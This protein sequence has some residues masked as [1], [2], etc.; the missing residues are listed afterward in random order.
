MVEMVHDP[1]IEEISAAADG[2]LPPTDRRALD[3]HLAGC[4]ECTALL[5]RFEHD[6]RRRRIDPGHAGTS[7]LTERVLATMADEHRRVHRAGHSLVRRAAAALAVVGIAGA[8]L[9]VAADVGSH[10]AA[11][12]QRPAVT[13]HA[14]AATFRA[15]E[16]IVAPGSTVEWHNDSDQHHQLVSSSG[17]IA[18]A[19]DLAPGG[20]RTE[21]FRVPGTYE[22]YC[23]VHA[24]MAGRVRVE[25]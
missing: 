6:R 11:D 17:A 12:A 22:F 24:A 21:T 14:D 25:T 10:Q 8:A 4:P 15:E 2:E 1:W 23:L 5:A 16:V 18:S 19:A 9:A 20:D 3:A 7:E 13:I